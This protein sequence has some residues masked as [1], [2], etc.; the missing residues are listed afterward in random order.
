M[1][2]KYLLHKSLVDAGVSDL[3]RLIT[4]KGDS[5]VKMTVDDLMDLFVIVDEQKLLNKLLRFVADNLARIP[6]V[7]QDNMSNEYCCSCSEDGS[8]GKSVASFLYN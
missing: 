2:A 8:A 6:T 7:C 3:P 1:N 5:K 4:R